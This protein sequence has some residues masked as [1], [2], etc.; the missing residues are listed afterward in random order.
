MREYG[1]GVKQSNELAVKWYRKAADQGYAKAQT[2]L[3][4][5]Y[6]YGKGVTMDTSEAAKWYGKAAKQGDKDA[7]EGLE[8]VLGSQ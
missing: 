8:R 6:E 1:Q 5:M 3:A 2:Y 4:D 7:A